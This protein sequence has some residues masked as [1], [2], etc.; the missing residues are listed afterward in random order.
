MITV[1]ICTRDRPIDLER[2][3]HN[4]FL[5][6][7]ISQIK[8]IE[9][10]VIDNSDDDK[11][12][13]WVR[14]RFH[15]PRLVWHFS[16]PPGLS[17][18]RNLA[19]SLAKNEWVAFLD[20]DATIR[21]GWFRGL[22]RA[23]SEK[24]V[25]VIGGPIHPVWPQGKEPSWLPHSIKAAYTILDYSGES[26][27]L[28]ENRYVYGANFA[29]NRAL[30]LSCGG[31]DEQLGRTGEG[32][33]SGEE[34]ELQNKIRSLGYSVYFEKSMAVDHFIEAN[35][36]N[37]EWLIRR[38][39]WEGF[40]DNRLN[41][42]IKKAELGPLISKHKL[43][44]LFDLIEKDSK[45]QTDIE[46]LA[47]IKRYLVSEIL[48]DSRVKNQ[49]T[50]QNG[51]GVQEVL[52]LET[53]TGHTSLVESI[54]NQAN[55][56]SVISYGD[57]W[58]GDLHSGNKVISSWSK[59]IEINPKILKIV[60][61]TLDPWLAPHRFPTFLSF[62]QKFGAKALKLILH[63][64]PISSEFMKNLKILSHIKG[65]EIVTFSK[66]L[67]LQLTSGECKAV[68]FNHPQTFDALLTSRMRSTTKFKSKSELSVAVIGEIRP[69]KFPELMISS[70]NKIRNYLSD[71]NVTHT[72]AI[73]NRKL[74]KNLKKSGFNLDHSYLRNETHRV[75]SIYQLAKTALQSDIG[76]LFQKDEE[77]VAA[78]GILQIWVAARK[79]VIA[80]ENTET[81]R[82][83]E[84]Y[85]L[86][87]VVPPTAEAVT[88]AVL[89]IMKNQEPFLD[90]NFV[91]YETECAPSWWNL[92]KDY[93]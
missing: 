2:S 13:E 58:S 27:S 69:G 47:L 55:F 61:I 22:K 26:F 56:M 14:D 29:V 6:E 15:D 80:L 17:K 93:L 35:R 63:R 30:A 25:G 18:A 76:L 16:T 20:D 88:S 92:V 10:L 73:Q 75:A 62:L 11:T 81:G 31:F 1:A 68:H 42:R 71:F 79:P 43:S 53:R 91:R 38:I 86:G 12:N 85:S 64:K 33:L 50:P 83:V 72:G 7:E 57:P 84:N 37:P 78:S 49:I 65:V 60:I 45:T 89:K 3:L 70:V 77:A 34:I 48:F 40:R 52:F 46:E 41:S 90:S 28:E 19:L 5:T 8:G 21:N 87:L 51:G 66:E 82:I 54:P 74:F 39:A 59:A 9:I 67:E 4:L 24:S 32:L 36:T 23:I 44:P